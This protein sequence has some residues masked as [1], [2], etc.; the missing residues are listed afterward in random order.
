MTYRKQARF[1]SLTLLAASVALPTM[2]QWKKPTIIQFD[3]AG[4]GTVS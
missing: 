1:L 4:A 2:A 3:A